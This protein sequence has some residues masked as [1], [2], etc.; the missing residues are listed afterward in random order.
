[1]TPFLSVNIFQD[2]TQLSFHQVL[3]FDVGMAVLAFFECLVTVRGH[4][5]LRAGVYT[6]ETNRAMVTGDGDFVIGDW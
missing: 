4:R 1:M 6:S 2:K 5:L 3:Q